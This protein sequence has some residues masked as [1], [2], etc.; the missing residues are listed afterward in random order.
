M[1]RCVEH[2]P[3]TQRIQTR[4]N[5]EASATVAN[6]L[7]AGIS[8]TSVK[9]GSGLTTST[10]TYTAI[11]D[12]GTMVKYQ[13]A[14]SNAGTTEDV[15]IEYTVSAADGKLF[16]PTSVSFDAVKVG[17]DNAYFSFAEDRTVEQKKQPS[18]GI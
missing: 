10:A 14:V 11:P 13:P 18:P 5:D 12:C 1:N 7:Q 6:E 15:M 17:T 4:A 9:V 2:I 16:T 8:K 3:N